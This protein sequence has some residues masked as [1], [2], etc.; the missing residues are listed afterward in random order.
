MMIAVTSISTITDVHRETLLPLSA[1]QTLLAIFRPV[2][3]TH[4]DKFRLHALQPKL[5]DPSR[6]IL[7]RRLYAPYWHA[8]PESGPEQGI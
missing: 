6:A 1:R 3:K 7:V 5:A 2:S 8:R 4:I